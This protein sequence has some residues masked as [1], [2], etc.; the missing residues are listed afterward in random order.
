MEPLPSP[1]KVEIT[2]RLNRDRVC[3]PF[4]SKLIDH[5][6]NKLSVGETTIYLCLVEGCGNLIDDHI[7]YVISKYKEEISKWGWT[8][9]DYNHYRSGLFLKPL[10][11]EEKKKI[12]L[13]K[14]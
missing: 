6:R 9:D 1:E 11:E 4:L 12:G 2:K 5:T 13:F 7:L 14:K 8:F 10:V 3:N